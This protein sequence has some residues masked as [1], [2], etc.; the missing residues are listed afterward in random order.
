MLLQQKKKIF[1]FSSLPMSLYQGLQQ[2]LIAGL[3]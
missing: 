2:L 1:W 3:I